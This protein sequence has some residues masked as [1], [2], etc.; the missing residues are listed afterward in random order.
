MVWNGGAS[1]VDNYWS[2][3]TNWSGAA[4]Q[5]GNDLFFGGSAGLNN[6]NDTTAGTIYSGINFNAGAGAFIL[7]G[8]DITL[9]GNITNR[10]ANVQTNNL[11]MSIA[12]NPIFNAGTAGMVIGGGITNTSSTWYTIHL[13]GTNGILA[14]PLL[15]S[16]AGSPYNLAVTLDNVA[17]ASNTWSIV[18]N[19]ASY[20]TN[21][22]VAGSGNITFGTGSDAPSLAITNNQSLAALAVGGT[23]GVTGYFTMNSG[24]LALTN[25]NNAPLDLDSA[26]S[27]ATGVFNMNGGSLFVSGKYLQIGDS[28]GTGIFNQNGGTVTTAIAND[29]ILG[30][31]INNSTGTVNIAAGTFNA[32]ANN[33]FFV[34][35]RGNGTWNISGSGLLE[36]QTLNMTRNSSDSA[37]ASGTLNLNGGTVTMNHEA[38]GNAATGQTGAIN[39]NGG[40]LQATAN[41]SSFLSPAVLP[42]VSTATV[43]SGGTII[44]DGGFA[45][46]VSSPLVHDATLGGSADGGLIKTGSGTL[47]LTGANT[48]TGNTVISNGTLAVNGSLAAGTA[49]VTTNGTLSGIGAVGGNVTNNGTI[50]PGTSALAGL[51]TC[52]ANVT[53]NGTGTNVMKLDKNNLTNDVL[54][55]GGNLAYGGT[56]NV[57]VLSGTLALNDSF[58]LFSAASHSGNFAVTNLPPLGDPLLAWNWNPTN[59]ILSVVFGVNTSSTNI[60][61]VVSGNQLTLSWP[62]DHTGWRLQ[63]QTNSLG[64]GI[65]GNWVDVP[66]STNV[67]SEV[68]TMDPNQDTVFYRMVYP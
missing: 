18:G 10:L 46:T 3:A 50:A 53:V 40:V 20:L 7:N 5:A 16:V 23:A 15:S 22:T 64:A 6:T 68:I 51:L 29:I 11:S 58:T 45:I 60:T 61:A 4:V 33:N 32:T 24:T 26:V 36:V 67:S 57:T 21:L 9:T 25:A 8:N 35:F 28:G 19:N 54:V 43:K 17:G 27:G 30:N 42:G 31:S 49:T 48:F 63:V 52:S 55:V 12:E 62:S 39:F 65:S 59:G 14:G 1:A 41:S 56:L 13:Q 37:N 47:T 66:G 38:M 34:G 44:N 2:D